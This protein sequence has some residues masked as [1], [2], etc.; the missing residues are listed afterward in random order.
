MADRRSPLPPVALDEGSVEERDAAERLRRALDE[1]S[2]PADPLL[3]ALRAAIRPASLDA[4]D[5]QAILERAL[6][7]DAPPTT[8]E[9]AEAERLR[10]ALERGDPA[11]ADLALARALRSAARPE[12]LS[13]LAHRAILTSVVAPRAQPPVVRRFA[14]PVTLVVA[15]AASLLLLIRTAPSPDDVPL[16]QARSTEDLFR[17]PFRP[18]EA[19][20]R[21]D[22]IALA[23]SGDFRD[24]RFARWGVR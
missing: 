19:S 21:I 1:G 13:E 4:T 20:A 6:A 15:M 18:G 2:A 10:D 5:H 24:N 14:A 7:E 11:H 12:P 17:E 9:L 22:R 23:R 8:E 16:A 3:D